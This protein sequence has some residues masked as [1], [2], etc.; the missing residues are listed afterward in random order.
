MRPGRA[1]GGAA[2]R[3]GRIAALSDVDFD[4][5]RAAR[6]Q[7]ENESL[8]AECSLLRDEAARISTLNAV[9]K[10]R[11][12]IADAERERLSLYA[13]AIERSRPWRIVQSLRG[14]M[15]RKW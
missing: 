15:G 13:H 11:L 6:L 9:L 12:A 3:R 4:P 10:S 14:F 7:V 2:A 5:Q 1:R 8:R